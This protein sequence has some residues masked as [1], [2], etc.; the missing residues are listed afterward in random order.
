MSMC[1]TLTYNGYA[2]MKESVAVSFYATYQGNPAM[3]AI[4]SDFLTPDDK[5]VGYNGN[6]R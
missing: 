6:S 3:I 1:S 2:E 5:V 4:Y